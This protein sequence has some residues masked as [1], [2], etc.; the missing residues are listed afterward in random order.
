M[1]IT[2]I[3]YLGM[4]VILDLVPNHMSNTSDLFQRSVNDPRGPDGDAFIWRPSK[5][6]DSDG[7]QIPPNNWVSI[8]LLGRTVHLQTMDQWLFIE[9]S[10]S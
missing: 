8:L 5:G 1:L 2:M 7:K 9:N 10:L 4:N 3:L 6:I